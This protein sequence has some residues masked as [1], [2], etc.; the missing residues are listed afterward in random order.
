MIHTRINSKPGRLLWAIEHSKGSWVSTTRRRNE[1]VGYK[2]V[3]KLEDAEKWSSQ[4]SVVGVIGHTALKRIAHELT[5]RT[6]GREPVSTKRDIANH[7]RAQFDRRTNG[8]SG[9]LQVVLAVHDVTKTAVY[10]MLA[11]IVECAGSADFD[12]EH[13]FIPAEHEE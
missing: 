2:L 13:E 3:T 1:I 6:V 11:D 5:P 4:S 7:A 9:T 12:L 10:G 8:N